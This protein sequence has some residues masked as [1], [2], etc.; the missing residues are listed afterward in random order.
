EFGLRRAQGTDGALSATRATYI[1]GCRSTSNV[2]AGAMHTIP[3]SGTHAHSWVMS[4]DSE[5]EAFEAY[6]QVMPNNCLLL[7]DTY[8][9]LQGVRNA[10]EIGRRLRERGHEL[11]GIRLDSGDL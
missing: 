11:V 8:D 5:I 1:G 3:V 4:F 9:T 10:I 6:S 7:V 2:L